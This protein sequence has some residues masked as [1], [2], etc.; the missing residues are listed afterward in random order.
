MKLQ[1]FI[2]WM[3]SIEDGEDNIALATA[4]NPQEING[5][6]DCKDKQITIWWETFDGIAAK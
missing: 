3:S 5:S 2:W 1:G 6:T 4:R